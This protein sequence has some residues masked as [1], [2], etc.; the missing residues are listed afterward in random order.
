MHAAAEPEYLFIRP[1]ILKTHDAFLIDIPTRY[2]DMPV[3]VCFLLSVL[4]SLVLPSPSSSFY[5]IHSF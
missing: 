3:K 1:D 4:P 5:S 2:R